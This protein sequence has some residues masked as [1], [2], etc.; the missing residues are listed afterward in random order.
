[1]Y[2]FSQSLARLLVDR[3]PWRSTAV[4]PALRGFDSP[5]SP[6]LHGGACP[7]A[8]G[9]SS[10]PRSSSLPVAAE[11]T[12]RAGTAAVAT[13]A[14]R[15][16]ERSTREPPRGQATPASTPERP[17]SR[18]MGASS[19]VARAMPAATRVRGTPVLSAPVCPP[20]TSATRSEIASPASRTA[21]APRRRRAARHE[22]G[23]RATGCAS[24][25]LR[26]ASAPPG[27]PATPRPTRAWQA[28]PLPAARVRSATRVIPRPVFAWSA[29]SPR[30]IAV[31]TSAARSA[32]RR[33]TPASSASDPPTVR[34]T[35][36]GASRARAAAASP[37][38]SARTATSAAPASAAATAA[39]DAAAT[40]RSACRRTAAGSAAAAGPPTA[41]P[42]RHAISRG[43]RAAPASPATVGASW[44]RAPRTAVWATAAGWMAGAPMEE[45]GRTRERPWTPAPMPAWKMPASRMPAMVDHHE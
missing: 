19:T 35:I 7:R 45:S 27:A 43:S 26:R 32:T 39:R 17:L 15:I 40:F 44:M 33:P 41:R 23:T 29:V 18:A 2:A 20:P 37:T 14:R 10:P 25:A 22:P 13:R 11:V 8:S 16:P 34:M 6:G 3:W 1:M 28:A 42:A 4:R 24:R 31:L 9:P 12:P 21:T 30:L 38:A 5:R 36:Q